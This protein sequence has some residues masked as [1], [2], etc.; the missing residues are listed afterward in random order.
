MKKILTLLPLLSIFS[1]G[2]FAQQA[3]QAGLWVGPVSSQISG[4]GLGGW[5]KFGLAGGAWIRSEFGEKWS[6]TAGMQFIQKGSRTK[7][8]TL[9]F[10]TFAYSLG[11]IEVPVMAGYRIKDW[12]INLGGFAGFLISQKI[13]ANGIETDPNPPFESIEVGATGGATYFLGEKWAIEL[14]GSSSILPVRHSPNFAN[15]L[16]YYERGNTNQVIQLMI[17][18]RF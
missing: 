16:S 10:Q 4:D 18:L 9:N 2:V 1:L 8:D 12:Q 15:S 3:F 6:A 11:Y 14:R 5:D 7:R 13:I 17:H